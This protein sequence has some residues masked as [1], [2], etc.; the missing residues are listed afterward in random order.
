MLN[1]GLILPD[2]FRGFGISAFFTD[3]TAGI[4]RARFAIADELPLYMPVQKHTAAVIMLRD[5][6][7]LQAQL[8]GDAVVTVRDNVIVGVR[9]ADC[10]PILLYD[11]TTGAMGA[12][13]AGWRGTAQG[14]MRAAIRAFTEEF[15]SRAQDILTAI[16]PSIRGC[17]YVVGEEV[18]EAVTAASG[19]GDYT[20]A[21][22]GGVYVDLVR[23]N[24]AQAISSDISPEHIWTSESCTFC[25]S[26]RFHSF[27]KEGVK[28]GSQGAFIYRPANGNM[29]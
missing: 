19:K 28:R 12:V 21:K 8:I 14:I 20:T 15:N 24:M 23:A 7:D 16:G 13:H 29:K 22:N 27:R 4:D 2:I 11:P 6:T 9:T 17:C 25:C 26:D 5:D 3:K 10:V 18:V 1:N